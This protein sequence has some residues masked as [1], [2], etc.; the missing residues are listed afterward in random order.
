MA[1]FV[2]AMEDVA[3]REDLTRLFL[4]SGGGLAVEN[5][6]KAAFDW[7]AKRNIARGIWKGN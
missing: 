4:V 1:E 2:K 5:A 7:K 6:F 3:I